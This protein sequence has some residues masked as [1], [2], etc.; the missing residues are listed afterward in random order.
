MKPEST[1]GTSSRAEILKSESFHSGDLV[2]NASEERVDGPSNLENV[3]AHSTHAGADIRQSSF[4]V[5]PDWSSDSGDS[6]ELTM[7]EVTA[8]MRESGWK[9]KF[10]TPEQMDAME[11]TISASHRKLLTM[12]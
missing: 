1:S 4:D 10:V 9:F 6:F 11:K 5:E 2:N 7:A 3:K 8:E 12:Y